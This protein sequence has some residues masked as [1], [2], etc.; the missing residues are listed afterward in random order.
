MRRSHVFRQKQATGRQLLLG[1]R[2]SDTKTFGFGA[3]ANPLPAAAEPQLYDH[4]AHL[5]TVAPTRSGKGA[6]SLCRTCCIT[7]GRW[8]CSIPKENF[9]KSPARR[10]EMGQQVVKLDPF[11]VIDDTT[12]GMNPFDVFTH[13]G[14]DIVSDGQMLAHLLAAG[15]TNGREPFGTSMV[16]GFRRA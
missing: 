4:D 13:P 14:G 3:S 10:R 5:I 7:R 1:W 9:T 12:D 15:I 2:Q 16:A 8:S 6:A 11:R